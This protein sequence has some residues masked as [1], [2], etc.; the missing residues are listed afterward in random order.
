LSSAI[1]E[2]YDLAGMVAS[3]TRGLRRRATL[4]VAALAAVA[5]AV[6]AQLL[7]WEVT[8][9]EVEAGGLRN[10][11]E[12]LTRLFA[13][14]Q[15]HLGEVRKADLVQTAGQIDRVLE[16]L[17]RGSPSHSIPAAWTP[18]LRRQIRRLEDV[19]G[20][21]RRIAVAGPY[22]SLR[23]L[24][25]FV[26]A[27]SRRADPLSLRYFD[28]LCSDFIAESEK[29]LAAYH[30]ECLK[31]GL[32]I[33]PTAQSSGYAAM[34]IERATKQAI[35]VVADVDRDENRRRLEAS[36]E[37]YRQVRRA[38]DESPFFAAALNPERGVSARAAAELLV[39]LRE[40]WDA[41]QVEFTM[42][43]AGDEKNFDLQRLLNTQA[44]LVEKVERLT[45]ALI[46]YASLTYGG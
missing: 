43:A 5:G 4:L 8:V 41:M 19:W 31:T 7:P 28:D 30:A 12:R 40:D 45:A 11:A 10:H 46:R 16:G 35:Y 14:Y 33:C 21:I 44:S 26:P 15:L 42:L 17:E 20:P 24:Q 34:V 32:E 9:A 3:A 29:L 13:L 2:A 22:E 39:S 18:A 25:E 38:N 36:I 1:E 23:V 6:P 37:T 27:E